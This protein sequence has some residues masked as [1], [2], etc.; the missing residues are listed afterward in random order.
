M[1]RL[2]L[3]L[4]PYYSERVLCHLHVVFFDFVKLLS[5][6]SC[7]SHLN[8]VFHALVDLWKTLLLITMSW[9]ISTLQDL[10]IFQKLTKF[11]NFMFWNF[12]EHLEV[13]LW[14]HTHLISAFRRQNVL[15]MGSSCPARTTQWIP[16]SNKTNQNIN[17]KCFDPFWVYFSS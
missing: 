11:N 15:H 9:S 10:M 17:E 6:V 4:K 3:H 5:I 7:F 1:C 12:C 14:W 2:C 16:V 13:Q 8:F